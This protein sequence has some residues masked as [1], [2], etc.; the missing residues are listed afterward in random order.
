MAGAKGLHLVG[1]HVVGEVGT[2]C[3]PHRGDLS[4]GRVVKETQG[5]A[6]DDRSI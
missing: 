5:I 4:V 1:P 2:G 3:V 6:N